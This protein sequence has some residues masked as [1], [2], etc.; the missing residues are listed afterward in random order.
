MHYRSFAST[1]KICT[2]KVYAFAELNLFNF[3]TPYRLSL[4]PPIHHQNHTTLKGIQCNDFRFQ[5]NHQYVRHFRHQLL[6]CTSYETRA[7]FEAVNSTRGKRR[8]IVILVRS[9]FVQVEN[10]YILDNILQLATFVYCQTRKRVLKKQNKKI[11][12]GMFPPFSSHLGQVV[13]VLFRSPQLFALRYILV[14]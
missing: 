7:P 1:R 13:L 8:F 11:S 2:V 5:S 6:R 4:N 12:P 3:E 10:R 14:S 9:F